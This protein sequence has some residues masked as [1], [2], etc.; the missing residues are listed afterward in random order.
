MV[1]RV[2]RPLR[3]LADLC[4]VKAAPGNL[5]GYSS[6]R[7]A[8]R[9]RSGRRQC[10]GRVDPHV[11]DLHLVDHQLCAS[12]SWRLH[13]APPCG[14]HN[15][16]ALGARRRDALA[17]AYQAGRAP[18][19]PAGPGPHGLGLTAGV[20]GN[21]GAT[22]EPLQSRRRWA[23]IMG[24]EALESTILVSSAAD[25]AV[26]PGNGAERATRGQAV[27]RSGRPSGRPGAV[28]LHRA[29]ALSLHRPR[30]SHGV[31]CT[32]SASWRRLTVPERLQHQKNARTPST[33]PLARGREM[34]V[35]VRL[36]VVSSRDLAWARGAMK[37]LSAFFCRGPPSVAAKWASYT[38]SRSRPAARLWRSAGPASAGAP[39]HR[40][41]PGGVPAGAGPPTGF[42]ARPRPLSGWRGGGGVGTRS[43][44]QAPGTPT[45]YAPGPARPPARRRRTGPPPRP[46]LPGRL[47][48]GR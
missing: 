26:G 22:I 39:G 18:P 27:Q 34:V 12:C 28:P 41:G 14:R 19:S 24:P 5:R 16:R 15:H 6:T 17:M 31:I 7:F 3:Y 43:I 13:L 21:K 40:A 36:K 46:C 37:M 45:W 30:T 32:L 1:G 20:V 11:P 42:R 33:D 4:G 8:Q 35:P 10:P 47:T 23:G 44:V 25:C 38:V 29:A 9:A 2:G 48:P